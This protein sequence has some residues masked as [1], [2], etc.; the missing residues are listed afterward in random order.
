MSFLRIGYKEIVD[1]LIR[2]GAYVNQRVGN[3]APL[4]VAAKYSKYETIWA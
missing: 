4:D 1:V 2:N 3:Q